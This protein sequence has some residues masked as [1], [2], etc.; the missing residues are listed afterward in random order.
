MIISQI[1]EIGKIFDFLLYLF[2]YTTITMF[3]YDCY[4]ICFIHY[5]LH[6][7]NIFTV[8]IKIK[9]FNFFTFEGKILL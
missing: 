5:L 4:T 2:I 6:Y 3:L 1:S 8:V 7:K 9:C